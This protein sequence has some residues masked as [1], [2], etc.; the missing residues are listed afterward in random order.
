MLF[1]KSSRMVVKKRASARIATAAMFGV[2]LAIAAASVW[3]DDDLTS[4]IQEAR[5]NFKPATE[6]QVDD[7]RADLKKQMKEL[8]NFVQPSSKNGQR[9]LRYLQWDALKQHIDSKDTKD[10]DPIDTTLGKLNRN[11]TG[12]DRRPFRHLARALHHYRNALAVSQWSNDLFSQQLD[13]LSKAVA[14]YRKKASAENAEAVRQ[15]ILMVD[16]TERA[17]K[18]IAA[19]HDE[20]A[21][22][23]AFVNV[24][25]EYI[26]AGANR[27]DRCEPV[28]DCIL[29]T[30]IHGNAHTNGTVKVVSIES[31]DKAVLELRSIGHIFSQDVGFNGPAVINSTSDTDFNATKRVE[32]SDPAFTA[33]S[34]SVGATTDT[35]VHS[36]GKQGGGLGSRL[37]SRI[38]WRKAAQTKG[39]V[40][41]I[42]A[43]HA[44]GRIENQFDDEVSDRLAKTRERYESEYRRPLERTGNVPEHILFRSKS[45]GLAMEVV[46][47]SHSEIGAPDGPP[48]AADPHDVTMRLH[49]TAVDNYTAAVMGGAT[50]KQ[51]SADEDLK[52]NVDLPSWMD[53]FWKQRKTEP[54]HDEA[55]RAE[56]FEPFTLT[57]N[58]EHPITVEFTSGKIILSLHMSELHSGRHDFEP[59]VV[60]A[61]YTPELDKRNGRIIL[62][63]DKDLTAHPEGMED[64]IGGKAAENRNIIEDFNKRSAQGTGFPLTLEFDPAR[65]EGELADAGKLGYTEFSCGNG[66]VVLGMDRM[67]KTN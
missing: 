39:Q 42:A 9:W 32:L 11:L 50:G 56:K 54:T 45:S 62:H 28:T 44:A 47:A 10:F 52:F 57:L 20:L 1:R 27:I 58:E 49:Q 26:S 43:Q 61:T 7:A 33:K 23:N 64:R 5:E 35:H 15:K 22:P 37:V 60:T 14:D 38:G 41:S 25:T 21:R 13:A 46:Q 12:L 30:N 8:E 24:S 19:V 34:S 2:T 40:D 51:E 6:E 17:P 66:W 63:R 59:W 48:D 18:V 53:R 29:G 31:D 4:Q 67:D 65:P 3:A 16:S 55:A 36:I